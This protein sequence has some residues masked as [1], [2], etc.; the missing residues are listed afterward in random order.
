MQFIKKVPFDSTGNFMNSRDPNLPTIQEGEEKSKFLII[1]DDMYLHSSIV[2]T[3]LGWEHLF[4]NCL[5]P[6]LLIS[7]S[8]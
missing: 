8:K 7:N 4:T 6:Q 3:V 1:R 5:R 2:K